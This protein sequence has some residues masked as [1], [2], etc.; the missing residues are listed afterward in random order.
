ML[1]PNS[2]FNLWPIGHVAEHAGATKQELEAVAEEMGVEP[3]L[4]LC[5]VP[6]FN[7]LQAIV[8]DEEIKFRRSGEQREATEAMQAK[9][10]AANARV[11]A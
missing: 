9:V 10:A 3:I 8:M 5:G 1:K 2:M 11:T 4:W 7:M 6:Y